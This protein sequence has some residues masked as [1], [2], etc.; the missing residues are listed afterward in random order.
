MR[1][2]FERREPLTYAGREYQIPYQGPGATGLGKPLRSILHGRADIP[3]VT[4]TISP[5][6]VEVAAEVADGFMP[7]WTSPEGLA[8]FDDALS[9][10]FAKAGG[11][12]GMDRFD[13]MPLINC[14]IDDDLQKCR[15]VFKPAIALYV[16][17]MGARN[18]NFYNNL[19]SRMGWPDAA[20]KIQDL[21]L[22]G[23]KK[24]ATATVPDDLV[25]AICLVGPVGHVREQLDRWKASKATTLILQGPRRETL[26]QMA[27]LCF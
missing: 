27:E 19:V 7:I 10:G 6:G 16:G 24:E 5:K 8:M 14:M 25:D 12:K 9:T 22:D 13:I 15:D 11:G 18:K 26:A 4:A 2:I 20:R 3:I 23:K 1:S 21:Y 17:G